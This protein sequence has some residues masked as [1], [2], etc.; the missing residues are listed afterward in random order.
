MDYYSTLGLQR[1]ASDAD[2][3]KAYRSMAMKH[4]PDR[5]GDEKKFKEIE[6]AYRTLSDPQKK[7]IFDLG[8]DPNNQH[9]GFG[10]NQGPFEFNFG[11]GGV[12]P[13]MEDIF[14]NFGFGNGFARRQQRKNKTLNIVVDI[15][16]EDV[17][18]GKE[19]NAEITLPDSPKQ[20]MI[21]ISIPAGIEHG[22]Q[23]RYEGMGDNSIPDIRAGDLIVNINVIRHPV[24]VRDGNNI[25]VEKHI[26]LWDAVLGGSLDIETLDRKTLK[27]N[28]PAGS[29]PDMILSCKN[30]GLP[31]IRSRVRGSLLIRIKIDIP[32]N[33]TIT[34]RNMLE[35]VKKGFN[36]G[37]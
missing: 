29:Q 28:I 35:E 30:E 11:G 17:L 16:L 37:K 25:I 4:H 2:I 13:G 18:N 27:I 10:F 33:L 23:I 32:K 6:E 26:D 31:H 24:F 14:H 5:G 21:N 9:S 34:Q 15:T 3:K 8:G 12:P 7:Q 1:G 20:K 19:L 22:Q 36:S